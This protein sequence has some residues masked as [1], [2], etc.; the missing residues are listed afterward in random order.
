MLWIVLMVWIAGDVPITLDI[1]SKSPTEA[2]C[3]AFAEKLAKKIMKTGSG[4]AVQWK[5]MPE[6][7]QI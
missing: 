5:C 1:N 4:T 6:K 7:P 3:N 2:G